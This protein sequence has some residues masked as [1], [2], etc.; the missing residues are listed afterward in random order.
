LTHREQTSEQISAAAGLSRHEIALALGAL[1]LLN[2][3][4]RGLK[5]GWKRTK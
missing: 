1:Q 2:L 5:G 4:E 3:A